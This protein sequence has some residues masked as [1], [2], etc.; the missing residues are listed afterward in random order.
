TGRAEIPI[1][2]LLYLA[3]DA[4]GTNFEGVGLLRPIEPLTRDQTTTMQ[5]MMAAVQRWALGTPD[6]VLDRKVWRENNP[7]GTDAQWAAERTAWETTLKSYMNY[8]RNYIVREGHATLGVYGG[9]MKD[10]YGFAN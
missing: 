7:G 3:R 1:S 8:E 6:V 4:E 9:E 10:S 2:R 5:A